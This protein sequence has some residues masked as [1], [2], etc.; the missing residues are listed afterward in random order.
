M[1]S[2]IKEVMLQ[3]R[4]LAYFSGLTTSTLEYTTE[5]WPLFKY[6]SNKIARKRGKYPYVQGVLYIWEERVF[7]FKDHS[8]LPLPTFPFPPSGIS[9]P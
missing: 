7:N 3:N 4:Q 5:E 1:L 9:V 2:I 8:S 6:V